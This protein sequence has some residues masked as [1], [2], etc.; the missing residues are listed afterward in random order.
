MV[1][2]IVHSSA[3]LGGFER[4][5]HLQGSQ[6]P[7]ILSV[8][9]VGYAVMQVPGY[10]ASFVEGRFIVTFFQEYAS[11]LARETCYP[12]SLQYGDLRFSISINRFVDT[13]HS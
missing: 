7:T 12:D 9:Y 11:V 3:R 6:F 2:H 4:D 5:L 13:S 1:F 10:V 8:V